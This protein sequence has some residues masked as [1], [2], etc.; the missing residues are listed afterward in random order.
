MSSGHSIN[1][2]FRAYRLS[3]G[4]FS[5][6]LLS[7]FLDPALAQDKGHGVSVR[8][9]GPTLIETEPSQILTTPFFVT[10]HTRG[11]RTFLENVQLPEGWHLISGEFPFELGAGKNDLRLVSFFVPLT[12]LAG[13]YEIVYAVKDQRDY[14]IRDQ[15][16]IEVVI[17]PMT[18]LEI[19]QRAVPEQIIAGETY[20]ADLL[21]INQSNIKTLATLEIDSSEGYP[22][23]S[24]LAPYSKFVLAPGTSQKIRVTVTTDRGIREKVMHHLTVRVKAQDISHGDITAATTV[25]VGIIPRVTGIRD[26]YHKIAAWLRITGVSEEGRTGAQA[27]FSGSGYLD[28]E[29]TRWI[30]FLVREPNMTD[31]GLLGLR[32]EYRLSLRSK[33]SELHVGDRNFSLSPLTEQ[34]KYGR[35]VEGALNLKKLRLGGYFV[36]TRKEV[37]ET[38]E[39]EQ[40]G[41]LGYRLGQ[42]LKLNFNYLNK[43]GAN[44]DS[45]IE[46]IEALVQPMESVALE[47]ERGMG[48]KREGGRNLTDDAWRARLTGEIRQK[49]NYQFEK[50]YAGSDYPGYY[51]DVDTAHG[52]VIIPLLKRLR[53]RA[54]YAERQNNLKKSPSSPNALKERI[55][56]AGFNYQSLLGTRLSMGHERIQN[57]DTFLP[58]DFHFEENTIHLGV[59]HS[60]DTFS[61]LTMVWVGQ[62]DNKLTHQVNDMERYSIH[63]DYSPTLRQQYSGYF[64]GGH[65]S[66]FNQDAGQTKT[67]GLNASY[68]L[69][70]RLFFNMGLQRNGLNN[71]AGQN[72][73]WIAG[74]SYTLLNQHAMSLR[75]RQIDFRKSD[76]KDSVSVV[77][78]YVIP[79]KIPVGRK[80]SFGMFQGKIYDAQT[81][82]QKGIPNAVIHINGATAVTD[83]DGEFLFPVL[84]PGNYF[85]WIERESLGINRVTTIKTPV[86]V[87]V[88]G[89][90]K[91]KID[92]G[93]THSALLKGK[94]VLFR[95][96][97]NRNIMDG[98]REDE[99]EVVEANGFSN[100]WLELE[101]GKET[102]TQV[103]DSNGSFSFEG[104][105][106]GK[107]RLKVYSDNLPRLHYLERDTFDLDLR[108]GSEADIVI[109]VLP[110]L[111]TLEIIEEGVIPLKQHRKSAVR[112]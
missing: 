46:S 5:L 36:G 47:L 55:T 59:G 9:V 96:I 35:G 7:L 89:G 1:W 80:K 105:R 23:V 73:Q 17:L 76:V 13:R 88:V 70:N 39:E 82:R 103:T 49:I 86:E 64:Q 112:K 90:K 21:V 111:R 12:T 24:N 69:M 51:R 66:F 57:E 61:F 40:A 33:K 32:D 81:P 42:R 8:P 68:K 52:T 87:T 53:F 85:L 95:P 54:F 25:V 11:Q 50:I 30:D 27:E 108:P 93:L 10:N 98:K 3:V 2:L 74:L 31:Q 83:Q 79:L 38:V 28:E 77:M 101:N 104:V 109:K 34:F 20:Q 63:A 106:P 48:R 22:A 97:D 26:P 84:K 14:K 62:F 94:A 67:A 100:L 110:R 92:I 91:N 41:F 107:W 4:F 72:D 60:F 65:Q 18:R 19:I 29:R 6:I 71:E 15:D 45:D 43:Q 99:K 78:T 37:G 16:R 102:I 75:A 44:G 56:Q 58:A